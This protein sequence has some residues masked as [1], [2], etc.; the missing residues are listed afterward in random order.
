M[1]KKKK[2]IIITSVIILILLGYLVYA[3]MGS[4]FLFYKT[5]S[6]LKSDPSLLGEPARIGGK[7]LKGSFVKTSDL[8]KFKITDGKENLSVVYDG[9][10]PASFREDTEVIAEGIY[11]K[12]GEFKAKSILVKC[13]SKYQAKLKKESQ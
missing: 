4:T 7:V 10:L 11:Q 12:N 5:V 6:E 8:Y 3:A 9:S 1:S 2:R 13:P